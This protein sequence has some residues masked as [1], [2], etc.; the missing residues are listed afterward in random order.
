MKLKVNHKLVGSLL[1]D[2][3]FN[4]VI[5]FTEYIKESKNNEILLVVDVQKEFDKF[6]P[7]VYQIWD[8]NKTTKVSYKFPNEKAKYEKKYG[9]SFAP[10]LK[11][12]SKKLLAQKPQENDLFKFQDAESTIVKVDNNHKFFYINEKLSNFF[13]KLKGKNVILVG[14]ANKEC[15]KDIYEALESYGVKVKYNFDYIYSS[16]T[17]NT[18]TH[19]L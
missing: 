8:S 11:K 1:N 10:E 5:K 2:N 6:I 15:L 16:E 13:K 3:K 9:T 17:S 19:E 14:G 12:I 4:M 18:Q 7:K